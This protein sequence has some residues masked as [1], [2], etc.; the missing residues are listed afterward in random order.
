[1]CGDGFSP[2]IRVIPTDGWGSSISASACGLVSLADHGSFP[3]GG[4]A[5]WTDSV[6]SGYD[7]DLAPLWDVTTTERPRAILAL[8]DLDFVVRLGVDVHDGWGGYTGARPSWRVEPP[9]HQGVDP[10]D[11]AVD[12]D[13]TVHTYAAVTDGSPLGLDRGAGLA[14]LVIASTGSWTA[15]W[16][17]RGALDSLTAVRG[18]RERVYLTVPPSELTWL[19]GTVTVSGTSSLL[20]VLEANRVVLTQPSAGLVLPH[21]DDGSFTTTSVEPSSNALVIRRLR[22]D[23]SLSWE[24]ILGLEPAGTDEPRADLFV[25][26][27]R[28]DGRTVFGGRVYQAASISGST[29]PAGAAD[30]GVLFEFDPCGEILWLRAFDGGGAQ[31][32]VFDLALAPDGTIYGTAYAAGVTTLDGHVIGHPTDYRSALF[33]IPPSR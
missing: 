6:V 22:A 30:A 29:L 19:D 27:R 12:P 13:G 17:A 24:R 31:D 4:T 25:G 9:I 8:P 20:V 33:A 7:H 26:M 10:H 14:E 5:R 32:G 21:D 16:L 23:S 2:D 15:R 11:S 18:P 1:V 28:P 3:I